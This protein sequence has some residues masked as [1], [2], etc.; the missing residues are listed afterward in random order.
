MT[1]HR[2]NAGGGL[3]SPLSGDLH[4]TWMGGVV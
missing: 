1:N 4:N 3:H 2:K